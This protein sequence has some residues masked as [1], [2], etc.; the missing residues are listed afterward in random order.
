MGINRSGINWDEQG[1][2]IVHYLILRTPC[3]IDLEFQGSGVA[4]VGIE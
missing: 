3:E 1:Y 2:I 4:D